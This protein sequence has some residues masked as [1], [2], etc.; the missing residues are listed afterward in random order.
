[1]TTGRAGGLRKAPKRGLGVGLV[2]K[3]Q[4]TLVFVTLVFFL[5]LEEGRETLQDYFHQ[6][7]YTVAEF[8]KIWHGANR[9]LRPDDPKPDL[10]AQ[11]HR[12]PGWN[13]PWFT[14][15]ERAQQQADDPHY[16]DKT[17]SPRSF[18]PALHVF[19]VLYVRREYG[20]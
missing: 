5:V 2:V 9:M 18:K 7:G 10:A 3:V 13:Q 6:H 17:H 8:G 1:M 20:R 15:A 11:Q 19:F 16:W 14:P 4:L 12:R